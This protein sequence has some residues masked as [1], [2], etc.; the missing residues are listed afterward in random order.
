MMCMSG[1]PCGLLVSPLAD[2]A[3][4]FAASPHPAEVSGQQVVLVAAH[5][6]GHM[7]CWVLYSR[8]ALQ[9]RCLCHVR[10][11]MLRHDTCQH[12]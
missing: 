7:Q 1:G 6:A 9:Q 5:W 12:A 8:L 2:S 3:R 11:R 4:H 10:S